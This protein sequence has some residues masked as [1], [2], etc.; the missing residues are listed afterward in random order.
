MKNNTR[1]QWPAQLTESKKI[2]GA[3]IFKEQKKY[4]DIWAYN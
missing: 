4:N 2:K 3:E 1:I